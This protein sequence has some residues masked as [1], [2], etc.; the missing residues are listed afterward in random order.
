VLAVTGIP[1]D[2]AALESEAE[3]H[4]D[5]RGEILLQAAWAW[6]QSGE[7]GCATEL[8]TEIIAAGGRARRRRGPG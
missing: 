1:S 2:A 6:R 5:E 4:P 7:P 3:E 8:L